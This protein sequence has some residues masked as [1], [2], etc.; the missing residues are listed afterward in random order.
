MRFRSRCT[1]GDGLALL[2][3]AAVTS[4]SLL[5]VVASARAAAAP[6]ISTSAA[7]AWYQKVI[8]DLTPLQMPLVNGLDA[9][10]GWQKGSESGSS[11]RRAIARDLPPIEDA[12]SNL[13]SL[14]TLPGYAGAG[15]EFADAIGLYVEAFRLESAATDLSPGTLVTQLQN[16]FE[17]VRELGDITF[18]QGTA[19]LAA[20]LGSSIAGSQVAAATHVP[21]W[22]ALGL[23]PA[24]PLLSSWKGTT[25]QPSGAQ[26]MAAWVAAVGRTGVPA[27]ATLR[28]A[29]VGPTSARKRTDLVGAVDRAEVSLSSVA[30]PRGRPH[31][32]DL[33]RLALLVD[34]EALLA[35]E[36]SGLSRG[37]PAHAL[38]GV[39]TTLVSVGRDL[40][41]TDR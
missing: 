6:A 24:E 16:S 33:L 13:E 17:R 7:Q 34:A 9:A 41:S 32:S 21:D 15:V 3:A 38:S 11:A 1:L 5:T 28:R 25:A 37:E 31:A 36:A 2:A 4:T 40:R 18:D 35:A 19:E 39:A 22:T 29:V 8:N 30:R 10:A 20:L 14:T 12:H 23:A 26:S 27:Q